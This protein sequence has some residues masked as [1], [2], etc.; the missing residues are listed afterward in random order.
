MPSR[1]RRI[2]DRARERWLRH[3]LRE[4]RRN[5]GGEPR[6]RRAMR[7]V[8]AGGTIEDLE[9]ASRALSTIRADRA[10]G[11]S[12]R[13]PRRCFRSGPGESEFASARRRRASLG[14]ATSGR[15]I[16]T[17]SPSASEHVAGGPPPEHREA[18]ARS[19]RDR[20]ARSAPSARRRRRPSRRHRARLRPH[21]G[22]RASPT[23]P[24][25]FM[26]APD[27]AFPRDARRRR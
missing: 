23:R 3:V 1:G 14:S 13:R 5:R 27:E 16:S 8:R 15:V 2:A 7:Q 20:D 12:S 22:R 19:R 21:P 26:T 24:V 11:A 9:F 10:I 6:P 17:R 4:R 18:Q 25:T